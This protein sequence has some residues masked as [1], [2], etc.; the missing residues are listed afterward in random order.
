VSDQLLVFWLQL[1]VLLAAAHGL[2]VLA[3]RVG[4]P[5]VIGALAAG[6]LLSRSVL[7]GFWPGG[8]AWLFP[9][10]PLQQGL[11]QG[12]SWIGVALLL[13]VAGFETDVALVR[14]LGRAAVAVAVG[15]LLLPTAAGFGLGFAIP[16]ELVGPSAS[17][18]VFALFMAIALGISALPVIAR[19]LAELDLMRRNFGQ[20]AL[21]AAMANDVVGWI[22]LGAVAGIARS[23]QFAVGPILLRFFAAF[24]F[25]AV[26]LGP[27]QRAVD[28]ILRGVMRRNA[29]VSGA[30]AVTLLLTLALGAAAQGLGL[31]PILGVFLGGILCGRSR[32]Q[33][34]ES[35]ARIE[36]LTSAFFAPVFFAAA[37]V[38]ADLSALVEPAVLGWGTLLLA[39]AGATKFAGA[40]AGARVVRL[41]A[42]EAFAI[43]AALNAR[44]A[45]GLIVATVGLEAGVLNPQSYTI[46]VLIAFVTSMMAPPVLRRVARRW[47]GS[48]EEQERLT[49]ERIQGSNLL[50][51]SSRIL[52]PTHGGSN[53]LL[54]AR[55]L[56]LVW[57]E[58]T[59]VTV[60]TAG[61]DVPASDLRRVLDLIE[62]MASEQVHAGHDALPAILE[63]AA[64]GYDAIV[65]GATERREAGRIVSGFVERL[66]AASPLPVIMVRRGFEQRDSSQQE[67]RFRR[68]LVPA[69]ATLPGRAAQEVAFGIARGL[70]AEV[71]LAHV[72]TTPSAQEEMVYSRFEWT[73]AT[74]APDGDEAPWL[75][76]RRLV[77][78]AQALGREMGVV[79][80][81]AIRIGL[82]VPREILSLSREGGADLIVLP[83]NL[84]HFSERPFL[85]YGVE[86]LLRNSECAVVVVS[87][88]AGW[89]RG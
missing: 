88:P 22:L 75:I 86:Y 61:D 76:A 58:G 15:S 18:P 11:L 32:H 56:D 83:A 38:K 1:F 20:I 48:A 16:R 39:A 72:V 41:P 81:T 71:L 82:S 34:A 26:A 49:R 89:R 8:Y 5:P 9:E 37:G 44:G 62:R 74:D 47:R 77:D 23:S 54:A 31:E 59:S 21:A 46:I 64:H 70:G 78:A 53:S 25:I 10:D 80:E 57:P 73:R 12:V 36:T 68:V 51:R 35:F 65:V 14:R 60:F 27:G 87:L 45:V 50:V 13:V 17:R 43:G 52:L 79:S 55:I 69:I 85:G 30:V 7:G 3:R 63:E 40:Y 24:V 6:L 84:R 67:P 33:S 2:G 4:Q 28:A 42:M 29:G 66:L 19:V